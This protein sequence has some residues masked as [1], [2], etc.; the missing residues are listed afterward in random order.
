MFSFRKW[1]WAS[2]QLFSFLFAPFLRCFLPNSSSLKVVS[3]LHHVTMEGY[4][5]FRPFQRIPISEHV[6]L[7]DSFG[8]CQDVRKRY[9]LT[10]ASL[11]PHTK[12]T[13][14]SIKSSKP[15]TEQYNTV[16]L[17]PDQGM[18]LPAHL[19]I[20]VGEPFCFIPVVIL[21]KESAHRSQYL[22]YTLTTH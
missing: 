12:R 17:T 6:A 20:A 18:T 13:S 9:Q 22:L 14:A 7:D 3:L 8:R 16:R 21:S 10:N 1:S 2:I 19:L 15:I 5:Y 11:R 4:Q